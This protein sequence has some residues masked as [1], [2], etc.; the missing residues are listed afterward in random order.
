M[1]GA[2]IA[3]PRSRKITEPGGNRAYFDARFNQKKALE[4][5]NPKKKWGGVPDRIEKRQELCRVGHLA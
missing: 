3:A 2:A 1:T 4:A 5:P